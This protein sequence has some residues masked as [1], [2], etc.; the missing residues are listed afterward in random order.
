VLAGALAAGHRARLYDAVVLKTLG[1]TRGKLVTAY[2]LE[3]GPILMAVVGKS[4]QNNGVA[5]I[6][7]TEKELLGELNAVAGK[8]L[9]FIINDRAEDKMVYIPYYDVKGDL[10]D[11]FT[12]Y[13]IL[14]K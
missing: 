10:R 14:K 12:C 13:P 11:A 2:A 8:P 6:L 9:H 4:V 7:L 3:Y 1:A 5:N